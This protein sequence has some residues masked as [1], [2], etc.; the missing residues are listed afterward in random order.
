MEYCR[1][2]FTES[3]LR[4]VALFAPAVAAGMLAGAFVPDR[5]LAQES[6]EPGGPP[7]LTLAEAVSRAAAE[8]TAVRLAGLSVERSEDR[9]DLARSALLP[10]ISAS[11]STANR[12]FNLYAMGFSIPQ[13]PGEPPMEA[14]VGPFAN[15]DARVHLSQTLFDPA[16]YRRVQAARVAVAGEEARRAGVRDAAAH[17]AAVSYIE[18][19]RAVAVLR[20]RR[21]DA[22]ISAEL[23]GLAEEQ[24]AAGVSTAIDVT[25][26]GTQDFAAIG[27]VLVA[28]NRAEQTQIGLARAIGADPTSRFELSDPAGELAAMIASLPSGRAELLALAA[29][30]R[31]ELRAV[32]V[33]REGAEAARRSVVAE[34]LPRVDLFADYGAS[35]LH[36]DDAIATRQVGVQVSI[37]LLDGLG[38]ESRIAEQTMM[39]Q[40]A[41]VRT[42]G[43]EDA[44]A[45]EVD[46]ILLDLRTGEQQVRI[47]QRRL[48]LAEAELAQA[49]ERFE[50]G[51]ASNI[52]LIQAQAS[53]NRARDAGI[54]ARF[55]IAS[56]QVGLAKAVGAAGD[57]RPADRSIE[58]PE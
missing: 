16:G 53:L 3:R 39:M 12:T 30:R 10:Q 41:A 11:A 40:A 51:I 20:A 49:R 26:A 32:E 29:R 58:L 34:R 50:N 38:R 33:M 45:A 47:A 43:V 17:G 46:A 27:A 5:A 22:R 21:A 37:P 55:A 52:E 6:R 24:L 4:I 15:L 31:P 14:L 48:E 2:G 56:A 7:T 28:E 54:E 13:A 9:V 23:L 42:H 18:A 25:R 35:G 57:I 36:V 8:A 1:S 19:A 44:V